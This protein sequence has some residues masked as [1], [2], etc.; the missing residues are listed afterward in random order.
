MLAS[1]QADCVVLASPSGLHSAQAIQAAAAGRHVMTEKPMATRWQTACH[2]PSLRRGRRATVRRQAEPPQP[3]AAAAETAVELG[4][5]G[6]STWSTSTFSGR[7]RRV[8]RQRKMA[9]HLGVRRRRIHESGQPL[10]RSSGL[11]RRAGRKRAW[12]TPDTLA[13]DIEVEDTGVVAHKWRNG[14]MGSINVTMLDY[15][16][17]LRRLD[18][19]PRR[20]RHGAHR[21]RGGQR[22]PALAVRRAARAW[23]RHVADASYQTT[24]VYGFGHPLYY[25]NVIGTLRGEAEAE[26]DG[27]E[28]LR[29]LELLIAMYTVGARRPARQSA[30][31]VLRPWRRRSYIRPPSS[32]QARR[33]VTGCRVWHFAHICAG[34]RIG[35]GLLVRPERIRRQRCSRSATTSRSRTTSRF[36]TR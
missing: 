28:G 7:G 4:A 21:R 23:T 6:E 33:S 12:P 26:T 20:E 17:N 32:M 18:H 2:G 35:T 5:S 24:S 27:R 34:A 14:A 36:T 10:R 8:L 11:V 15:P 31:G 29:S 25:D 19:D 16:K 22:D 13:R 9:R 30:A 3:D 1:T